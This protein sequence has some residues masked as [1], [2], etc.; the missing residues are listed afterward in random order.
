MPQINGDS[1]DLP[2]RLN[3]S[4][5]ANANTNA[6]AQWTDNA[7]LTESY[8]KKNT[9]I[10]SG[11][12]DGLYSKVNLPPS[13]EASALLKTDN[14]PAKPSVANKYG[15]IIVSGSQTTMQNDTTHFSATN[16]FG[17]A[18][19][20]LNASYMSTQTSQQPF[21]YTSNS[22]HIQNSQT[23]Q[24]TQTQQMLSIKVTNLFACHMQ[25]STTYVWSLTISLLHAL[26][27]PVRNLCLVL[28][29]FSDASMVLQPGQS[30]DLRFLV[31]FCF[32]FCFNQMG[33]YANPPKIR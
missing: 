23:T 32:R 12:R 3:Q 8:Y 28:L 15:D 4:I 18:T 22:N 9:A 19:T 7:L 24:Q 17:P 31:L 1:S 10:Q 20:M 33:R 13:I 30:N 16:S 25:F 2:L 26:T 21:M 5:N 29:S 6:T 11:Q 27:H 14:K